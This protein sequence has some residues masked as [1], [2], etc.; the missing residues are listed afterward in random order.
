MHAKSAA[1]PSVPSVLDGPACRQWL[2]AQDPADPRLLSS[3]EALLASIGESARS[4][5]LRL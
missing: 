4:P 2:A 1:V 3:V 5:D